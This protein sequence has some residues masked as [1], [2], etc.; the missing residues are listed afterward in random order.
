MRSIHCP[1]AVSDGNASS[2]ALI[3]LAQSRR[4]ASIRPRVLPRAARQTAR[5]NALAVA[6]N[7]KSPLPRELR[8]RFRVAQKHALYPAGVCRDECRDIRS[9]SKRVSSVEDETDKFRIR[10]FDQAVNLELAALKL[11]S[12]IVVCHDRPLRTET[13]P[14]EFK[15]GTLSARSVFDSQGDPLRITY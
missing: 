1:D 5:R 2:G 6:C 3:A 4:R 7:G 12:V 13:S 14:A 15:P 8:P 11:E 9:S 10:V